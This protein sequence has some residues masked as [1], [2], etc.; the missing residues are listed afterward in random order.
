M[1]SVIIR[2][3]RDIR[4]ADLVRL[5]LVVYKTGYVRK[6]KLLLITGLYSDWGKKSRQF[7]PSS[8]DN[9]AKNKL[10]QQERIR[11]LRVAEKWEYSGK[12]WDPLELIHYYD[13]DD[14]HNKHWHRSLFVSQ[15]F[16][17]MIEEKSR[18]KRIRNGQEFTGEQGAINLLHVQRTLERFTQSQYGRKFSKCRFRDITRQ[19]VTDFH[20][21]ELKRG[22]K[23]G[24]TGDVD[25]KIKLLYQ[26]CRKAAQIGVYGVDLSVFGSVRLVLRQPRFFSKAVSHETMMK[27]ETVNQDDLDKRENFYLDLFLF[28]YYA[29]GMSGVDICHMEHSWIKNGTI[30]YERIKYPNRARVILTDKAIAL[31]EKY[32][33]EAHM[34]YVFPVFKKRDM[35]A[36]VRKNRCAYINNGVNGTLK[37]VCENLEVNQKITWSTAR[38]SFITK[39]IDEGYPVLQICEQTGNSPQTI[40][41]HYYSITNTEEMKRKMDK[42]F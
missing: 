37:K 12:N 28:S 31:I 1:Y 34:D 15:V 23:N 6:E 29:G 11:Y 19:F 13:S 22:T 21:H 8:A 36:K 26:V 38:S 33:K 7:N 18:Q 4:Y 35:S 14:K 25:R 24:N 41:K 32:R 40:Y 39:M 3:R 20:Y 5:T 16:D 10:L 27:I 17:M 9:I 2:G 30:E 42:I